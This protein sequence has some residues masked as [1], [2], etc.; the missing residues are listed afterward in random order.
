MSEPNTTQTTIAALKE[1]PVENFRSGFDTLQSFELLQRQAK[2]FASSS[3]VP[4][5][6][7]NNLPN[8]IIA[9]EMAQRIGA[10]PLQVVQNLFV[11]H[12][13]PGWSAQFLIACMNQ[14]GRFSSIRYRWSGK[15]GQD[16][17]GCQAYATERA[18]GD[19]I[20]GP[21]ITIGLAKKEG[22]Y[23]KNGSK[24]QTIPQLMLMY[25]AAAWLVRTHAPEI[26]MG[27]Q[28]AEELHDVFDAKRGGDGVYTVDLDSMRPGE[29]DQAARPDEPP[30]DDDEGSDDGQLTP[31]N[32]DQETGEVIEGKF[33]EESAIKLLESKR[34]VKTLDESYDDICD[35]YRVTDRDV[36]P[37]SV[38]VKYNEMRETLA[39]REKV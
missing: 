14:S 30:T 15:E 1:K 19:E 2:A 3:L 34:T 4:K 36:P 38:G 13:R 9:L 35:D 7:Q 28:T 27:L 11:V 6:Y 22:W 26:S 20:V 10:S 37:D 32:V 21:Q 39:E 31:G 8:C 16:D 33:N 5:E 17:W 12:G 23:Q 29:G 18:T 24:W 25:R